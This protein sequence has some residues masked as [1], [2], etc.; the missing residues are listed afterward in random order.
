MKITSIFITI[1]TVLC[2]LTASAQQQASTQR[3]TPPPMSVEKVK[4]NIFQVK[5]GAGANTGFFV[6]DKE[7]IVIDAKM[8]EESAEQMI[9][10]IKKVTSNPITKIIITHSDGDHVNGLVGFPS[11][12]DII[13]HINTRDDMA[14]AFKSDTQRAFLPTMTFSDR[15]NIFLKSGAN[16][17]SVDLL[18]FGPAHTSGDAVVVFPAEK[19]AF[20]G[21]LLFLGRDPLIHRAKNGTS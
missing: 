2:F 19:V 20:I 18:Y 8:T 5:G 13:S 10:E 11:G 14:K 15:L 9:N 4:G 17:A 21:D 3:Q 7:V 12:L 6:A 16:S 1:A